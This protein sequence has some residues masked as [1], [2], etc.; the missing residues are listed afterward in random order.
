MDEPIYPLKELSDNITFQFKSTGPNG[1]FLKEV[2]FAIIDDL[3]N[4]YQLILFDVDSNDDR[5]VLSESKNQDMNK[6]MATVI[7]CI[8]TFLE[9][10]PTSKVIFS[11]STASRTRLYRIIIAKLFDN[12]NANFL[13]EGFSE[14]NG[15]EPF[16]MNHEYNFFVISIK[17]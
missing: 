12:I 9:N 10:T 3:P 15:F 11:G 8:T 17:S 1:V 14:T 7:R 5:S 16:N 6:I 4:F 13:I 2:V